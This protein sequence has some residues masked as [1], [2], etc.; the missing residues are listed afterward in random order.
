MVESPSIWLAFGGLPMADFHGQEAQHWW[1]GFWST[2][3][4][5]HPWWAVLSTQIEVGN[6]SLI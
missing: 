4:Q 2:G 6:R 1:A 3:V 5:K